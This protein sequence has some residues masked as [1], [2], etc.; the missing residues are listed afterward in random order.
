MLKLLRP[1]SLFP[2]TSFGVVMLYS[3]NIVRFISHSMHSILGYLNSL[4]DIYT[5]FFLIWCTLKF[6]LCDFYSSVGFIKC[7]E[8]CISHCSTIQ[9]QFLHP[10]ISLC[11]RFVVTVLPR[12][13]VATIN[14]LF[15]SIVLPFPRKTLHI[16]ILW[17]LAYFT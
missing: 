5:F 11:L 14:L 2:P 15:I 4:V 10:K 6:I 7:I 17:G 8:L 1:A 12:S 16:C 9:K 13:P 3:S